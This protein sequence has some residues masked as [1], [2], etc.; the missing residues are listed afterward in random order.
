MEA[1]GLFY[2]LLESVSK[3]ACLPDTFHLAKNRIGSHTEDQVLHVAVV[4]P[5][6]N[7]R[8]REEF[9]ISDQSVDCIPTSPAES[10]Y[11]YS[12]P[13]DQSSRI[14][15]LYGAAVAFQ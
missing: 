9:W 10:N 5:I 4:Q 14:Q 8:R 1:R 13:I 6:G 15:T 12:A 11:S 2:P 7:R 3:W